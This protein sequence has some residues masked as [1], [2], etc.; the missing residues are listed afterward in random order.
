MSVRQCAAPAII[1]AALALAIFAIA[2]GGSQAEPTAI[3]AA[4][5]APQPPAPAAATEAP[6]AT[7]ASAPMPTEAATVAAAT[8]A[9]PPTQASPA[10]ATPTALPAEPPTAEPAP[11]GAA[12]VFTLG[13]GT[14]ARYRVEEELASTGS[15]SPWAKPPTWPAASP[16]TP[17]AQ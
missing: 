2:C 6:P 1:V 7:A 16:S 5:Q 4:T 3:P 17:T 10:T 9:P 13:E 11:S 8:A 14:V 12:T 15:S